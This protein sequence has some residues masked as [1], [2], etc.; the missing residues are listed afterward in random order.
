MAAAKTVNQPLRFHNSPVPRNGVFVLSGYGIRVQANAGHLALHDGIADERRTICLPRVGHGLHRLV[1]IGSDGFITLEASRWLADQDVEFVMLERNGK[2]ICVTGPVRSS[3][4]RSRCAQALAGQS[5][6]GIQIARELIEKK[7]A[8]QEKVARYKLLAED[9]ADMIC[10]YREESPR[11]D[12]LE[13]IC[14]I[15]SQRLRSTGRY[16]VTAGRFS[17]RKTNREYLLTGA[18]SALGCR[19]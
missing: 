11:A 5:M 16:G 8:G 9:N 3:D 12:T 13:R 18:H 17:R 15:E 6:V 14:L 1:M 2:V 4:A 19:R 7:L 10:R